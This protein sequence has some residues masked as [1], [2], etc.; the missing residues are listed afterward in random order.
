MVETISKT[1]I[2]VR[3]GESELHKDANRF[4]GVLDPALT[5][6]G[7]AQA[8]R[9]RETLAQ[10]AL[11]FDETW[12]SP[13]ERAQQT[14][15]IILPG[16]RWQ[17]MEDLRELSFGAWEGLTK[18]EARA[19]TPEAYDAWDEDAYNNAPPGGESGH[20]AEPGIERLLTHIESSAASRILFVSHT[21]FLRLF[22]SKLIDLPLTESRKRLDVQM[23]RIGMLEVSGR[24]GKLKALNL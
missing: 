1:I 20:Q 10:L 22:I 18:E 11:R 4:C 24:K 3:H 2:F 12:T 16:A 15:R 9:A 14:A 7:V 23:G 5:P 6:N 21:T 17:V 8:G 13:R 19:K